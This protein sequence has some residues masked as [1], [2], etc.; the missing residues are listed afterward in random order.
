[1]GLRYDEP[2]TNYVGG[3]DDNDLAP[4]PTACGAPHAVGNG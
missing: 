2:A 4:L 1:M 3:A